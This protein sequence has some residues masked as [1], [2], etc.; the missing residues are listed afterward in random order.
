MSAVNE[1]DCVAEVG[2]IWDKTL[3]KEGP[4]EKDGILYFRR[5]RD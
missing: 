3:W 1:K 4:P 2:I 5:L